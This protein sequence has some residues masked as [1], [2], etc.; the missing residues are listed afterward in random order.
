ME[1]SEK[2]ETNTRKSL[3]SIVALLGILMLVIYGSPLLKEKLREYSDKKA[4]EEQESAETEVS[5]QPQVPEALTQW[6][7]LVTEQL[8]KLDNGSARYQLRHL[9]MNDDQ[10]CLLLD[11]QEGEHGRPFDLI[12]ERDQFG[13]YISRDSD[14][15]VKIYPPTEGH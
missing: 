8:P 1:Q 5:P 15:P 6:L 9:R 10:S 12:L 14:I 2:P 13:R 11:L 7:P 4:S 3:F